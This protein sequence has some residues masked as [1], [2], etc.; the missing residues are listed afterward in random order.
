MVGINILK[1][2]LDRKKLRQLLK[3]KQI[4]KQ[5]AEFREMMINQIHSAEE[6]EDNT[7][8]GTNTCKRTHT[9]FGD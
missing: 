8:L 6:E 3:I 2:Y 9:R 7:Y 1:Q 5:E 4:T